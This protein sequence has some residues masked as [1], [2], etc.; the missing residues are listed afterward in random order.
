[1]YKYQVSVVVETNGFTKTHPKTMYK[2]QPSN[3]HKMKNIKMEEYSLPIIV[4]YAVFVVEEF[5]AHLALIH[6]VLQNNKN[7]VNRKQCNSKAHKNSMRKPLVCSSVASTLNEPKTRISF[8]FD[9]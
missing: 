8:P 9:T 3:V 5:Q 1:M 7:Y 6:Q 4:F 2:S